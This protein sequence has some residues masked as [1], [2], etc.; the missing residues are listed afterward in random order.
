[1]PKK[2]VK[3]LSTRLGINP[4]DV[5]V[6]DGLQ[7][8]RD[9][10]SLDA[11]GRMDLQYARLEPVTHRRFA[12]FDSHN[13]SAIF[14]A[15]AEGDVLLHHPYHSFDTS[16][17]RLL[18]A[19]SVDPDVLAIK[20][21]IYRT[22][23]DSPIIRALVE[24]ARRGKQVV[25]LVE[26]TARF[27]EA[28]NI[29]WGQLLEREGAHVAYGVESLKT[30]VKLAL[31]VRD[32]RGQIRR[33]LHV[34]TGNYHTGTARLYE[35]LGV[36]TVDPVLCEEAAA[37][38]NALTGAATYVEHKK[39][40]V[41]P[42]DMR[43]RFTE[44]IAREAEHAKAGRPC[45]IHAKM[46]QLQDP[47]IIRE[48]YRAGQAGVPILLNVRG[49][50]C[51]RPGVL[52]LSDNIRVYSVIGRFLEHSRIYEFVN[53]GDRQ[54]FIGSADW[55]RRNLSAR[56][57]TIIPVHNPELC[58]E[59][60]AI[61]QVYIDDNASAWDGQPDGTYQRRRPAPGE[62]RRAAQEIFIQQGRAAAAAPG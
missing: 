19:A 16:V 46:N 26:I 28:P 43:R 13:A 35:D 58:A 37:L 23:S 34:G 10:S 8:I 39:L 12:D 22:S 32:E 38:F 47:E 41:A 1:M 14:E 27:D 29:A 59:L 33:Y 2:L 5:Y 18:E 6:V 4:E 60:A 44:L 56:V 40:M 62:A 24:A 20:L 57:E 54:Y 3:W 50:C 52:G 42:T 15:I 7:R 25:V 51:L 36:L 31:V 53:G 55:M 45:G 17:L 61:L 49:L 30:H 48:L 11:G 9:L 21:T